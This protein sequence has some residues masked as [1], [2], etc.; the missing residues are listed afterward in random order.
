MTVNNFNWRPIEPESDILL[1]DDEFSFQFSAA[2]HP[3]LFIRIE[4]P[5]DASELRVSDFLVSNDEI[6]LAAQAFQHAADKIGIKFAGRCIRASN[7]STSS[8]D[9]DD[10]QAF[11]AAQTKFS[12]VLEHMLLIVDDCRLDRSGSR[13]FDI[14]LKVL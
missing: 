14:V 11:E 5:T 3:R 2:G 7:I 1:R 9:A 13:S 8:N 10:R 6:P 4:K 12:S